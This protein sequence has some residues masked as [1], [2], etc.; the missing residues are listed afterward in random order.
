MK[1]P[2][3][4]EIVASWLLSAKLRSWCARTRSWVTRAEAAMAHRLFLDAKRRSFSRGFY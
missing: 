2:R 4:V 3:T 1:A